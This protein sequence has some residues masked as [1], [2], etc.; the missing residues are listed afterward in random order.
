M[1][2]ATLP[3]MAQPFAA[4]P[5]PRLWPMDVTVRT[6]DRGVQTYTGLF[7]HTFDAYDDALERFGMNAVRIEVRVHRPT[8]GA[9]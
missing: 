6:E 9:R 1:S 8:G 4:A 5:A 2:I 7:A 3:P